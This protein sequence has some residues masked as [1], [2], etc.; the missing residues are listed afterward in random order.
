MKAVGVSQVNAGPTA[1]ATTACGVV[2]LGV[3]TGVVVV[4]VGGT[5][6]DV[7]AEEVEPLEGV[8]IVV[9]EPEGVGATV[10]VVGVPLGTVVVVVGVD[11]GG[12]DA[13]AML[14]TPAPV[15]KTPTVTTFMPKKG[16][17]ADRRR[18]RL[19]PPMATS[20]SRASV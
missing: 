3:V 16:R 17:N 12:P 2:V 7:G 5:D 8:D 14:L 10:V 1:G 4:V 11:A 15:M 18:R 6:C 13:A 20:W 9:V 19:R